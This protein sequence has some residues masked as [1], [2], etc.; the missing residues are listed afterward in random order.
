MPG[1]ERPSLS[2]PVQDETAPLLA[3]AEEEASTEHMLR[4]TPLPRAQLAA[5]YTIKLVVP[6][7]NTQALPYINKMVEAYNLPAGASVGYY[8]GLLAL[9][10]SIGHFGS[11]F[12]WGR[13]SGMRSQTS[14]CRG[15]VNICVDWVG[16]TPVLGIGMLGIA[17]ASV[18]FGLSTTFL[19]AFT[20]RLIRTSVY[21]TP[22]N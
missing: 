3:Q 6:V 15:Y 22:Y 2:Q 14:S 20:S 1:A 18:W 7:A 21:N 17:V 5:I 13:L 19:Q 8:S 11:I 16:R 12:S 9:A 4:R 10:L